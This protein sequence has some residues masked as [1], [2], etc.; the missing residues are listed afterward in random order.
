MPLTIISA[1]VIRLMFVLH[2]F[3]S[4]WRVTD[5]L[6][7]SLYWL[8]LVSLIAL[9]V[10]ALVTVIKRKGEEW[11][12]FCPSFFCYLSAVIPAVWL[13]EINRLDRLD[14]LVT[15]NTTAAEQLSSL[16]G[17]EVPI[18]LSA[19]QWVLA[20]EQSLLFLLI[21]ARWLLPKGEITREQLSQLL[22]AYIGMASD[23]MELLYLFDEDKVVR[24]LVLRYAIL[25]VWSLSLFQFC[26]VYTATKTRKPRPIFIP[27]RRSMRHSSRSQQGGSQRS[28]PSQ[29]STD[30]N[31]TIITIGDNTSEV[32][33]DDGCC[34]CETEIWAIGLIVLLQD[35]PFLT[36]RLFS[37]IKYSIFNYNIIF[38]TTKNVLVLLLQ[39]YRLAVVLIE[40]K[41]AQ[42]EE[43]KR[44]EE[45]THE[46]IQKLHGK[47]K[48]RKDKENQAEK[49]TSVTENTPFTVSETLHVPDP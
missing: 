36:V 28:R 21:I 30:D 37:I 34:S 47:K 11:K 3:I 13:L 27:I 15:G 29:A 40:T 18:V 26:L 7:E 43:E 6:Q 44:T 24:D 22:F 45:V 1:V 39:F 12:W 25:G 20:I 46:L 10:E 42:K 35:G 9:V 49:D 32:D 23:I 4:V 2:T 19:N 31:P 8:M 14:E 41:K 33:P 48:K 17:V 5:V 38:F 16:Y